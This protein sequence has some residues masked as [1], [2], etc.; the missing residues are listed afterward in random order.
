[1]LMLVAAPLIVLAKPLGAFMW[2][3]PAALRHR[4]GRPFK[5]RGWQRVWAWLTTPI[6][7]WSLHVVVLW[8]WHAPA[9]FEA[10]LTNR[11]VHDLQHAS[12][13]VTALLFWWSLARRAPDAVAM[14]SLV[15]TLVH[16]GVLGALL[17]FAPSPWYPTYLTRDN[18]WGLSP[19]ADQQL[20]GLIMWVPAGAVFILAGLILLAH[21]L[22]S[23]EPVHPIDWPVR[24]DLR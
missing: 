19:L 22:R 11:A 9:W 18:P 7:A 12:F 6:T 8:G 14:L 20:G 24:K 1:M 17:T 2:S 21:W 4:V 10:S 15:T 16:T 3:L 23:L 5:R 13:L